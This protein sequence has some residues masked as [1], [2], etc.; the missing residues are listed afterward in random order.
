MAYLGT[1]G[2]VFDAQKDAALAGAGTVLGI[3]IAM[4]LSRYIRKTG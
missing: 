2:D 4:A 1:Q 3:L